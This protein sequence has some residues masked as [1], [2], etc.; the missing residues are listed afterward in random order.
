MGGIAMNAEANGLK[1]EIGLLFAL[2][3]VIGTII[4]SGVFMKPGSVLSYSGNAQIALFAW[5]LGGILTLAGG[6]TIAELGAQ[7]PKTGG[8]YT[9]LE[10]IYGEFWGSYAAGCRLSSTDRPSSAH[11]DYISAR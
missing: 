1:K 11:S 9:Y 3:L 4:G 2:S 10:E 7:I 6:L 8:L 5:L